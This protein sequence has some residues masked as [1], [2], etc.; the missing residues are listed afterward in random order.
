MC[1]GIVGKHDKQVYDFS[2]KW[3]C[4]DAWSI[5]HVVSVCI[6]TDTVTYSVHI[7]AGFLF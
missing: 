6:S 5:M 1:W 2:Y 7:F 3:V 4:S